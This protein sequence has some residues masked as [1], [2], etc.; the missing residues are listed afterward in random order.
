MQIQE[1]INEADILVP[2]GVDQAQKLVWLNAI[3]QDFFNVVKIPRTK[4]IPAVTGTAVYT[5]T[6]DIQDKNVFQVRW[7]AF[8][9]SRLNY[10]QQNVNMSFFNIDDFA[11]TLTLSPAPFTT[12]NIMI[13]YYYFPTTTYVSGNLTAAPDAPKEYHWTYIPALAAYLAKTEDDAI[14]ASNF[15]AE[16]KSA[17]NVASQ[18]YQQQAM[19][20]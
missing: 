10:D 16:Y 4:F 19:P 8:F 9:Y 1:I 5:V 12:G 13:G 18:N 20:L 6:P 3:N 17:W 15:E 2:N 14:K 7:N 11:Q